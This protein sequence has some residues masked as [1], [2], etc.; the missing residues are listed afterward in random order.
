MERSSTTMVS[1]PTIRLIL[2]YGIFFLSTFILEID[3]EMTM[4]LIIIIT[5]CLND[6]YTMLILKWYEFKVLH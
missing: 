2:F 1:F 4:G 3:F 6:T 5:K